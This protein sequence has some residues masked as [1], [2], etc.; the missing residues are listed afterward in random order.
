MSLD[1]LSSWI[2]VPVPRGG[3]PSPFDNE[4]HDDRRLRRSQRNAG[5]ALRRACES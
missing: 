3:F 4:I 5:A 2:G 1:V